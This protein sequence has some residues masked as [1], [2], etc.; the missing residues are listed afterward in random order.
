MKEHYQDALEDIS[1]VLFDDDYSMIGSRRPISHSQSE[2]KMAQET[3]RRTLVDAPRRR[4][5]IPR[6]KTPSRST[7]RIR[8]LHRRLLRDLN[9]HEISIVDLMRRGARKP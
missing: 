1:T 8:R 6:H 7:N 3:W 5:S 4:P 2:V 9:R